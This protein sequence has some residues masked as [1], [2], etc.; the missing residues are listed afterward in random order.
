[1]DRTTHVVQ[2]DLVK[3]I[4]KPRPQQGYAERVINVLRS[5]KHH[6]WDKHINPEKYERMETARKYLKSYKLF[7]P[8]Y[9]NVQD[10]IHK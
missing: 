10:N 6:T 1:M 4:Q 8:L 7:Y 2:N 5:L 3:T 9:K